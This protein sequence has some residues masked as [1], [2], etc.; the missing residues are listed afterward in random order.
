[1]K[2]RIEKVLRSAI[3]DRAIHS[4]SLLYPPSYQRETATYAQ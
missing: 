1:M 3:T 2:H 4:V